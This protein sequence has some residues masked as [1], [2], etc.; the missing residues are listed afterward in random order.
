MLL[1]AQNIHSSVTTSFL[2]VWLCALTCWLAY[3][4]CRGVVGGRPPTA[5]WASCKASAEAFEATRL[6]VRTGRAARL[7]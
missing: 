7:G 2:L 5:T 4:H 1:T 3:L 6:R